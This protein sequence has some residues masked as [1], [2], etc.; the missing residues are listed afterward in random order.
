MDSIC[1]MH[2][3]TSCSDGELSPVQ[4][5][6]Y[7][8]D[9]GVKYISVTDHDN[10]DFYLNKEALNLLNKYKIQYIT[11]C[12]F[13]CRVGLHPIEILGY[14]IDVNKAK[15]YLD[16]HGVPE[17]KMRQMRVK[18]SK[19]IFKKLGYDITFKDLKRDPVDVI[20][21]EINLN[22]QLK[23]SLLSENPKLLDSPSNLLRQGLNDP[24]CKLFIN[25][26]LYF[27]SYKKIIKVIQKK[28]NGLA[29][30]A[31]PY[32]Y[33]YIME[34][35]LKKCVNANID[36]IECYH[37]TVNSKEKCNYLLNYAKKNNLLISGGS[38]FHKVNDIQSV[39]EK[40]MIKIPEKI[41]KTIKSKLEVWANSNNY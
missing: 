28:L 24:R 4:F 3:H 11:G 12:E 2:T 22:T 27:P 36:G 14:G 19:K 37:Y 33:G 25:P 15:K 8:H 17:E 10:V 38:D 7:V 18:E 35:I 6:N 1:D 41:F 30:V 13:V 29:I 23:E 39:R 26:R 21:D 32:H 9:L 34:K 31:H 20:Y 5:V 16:K 40:K